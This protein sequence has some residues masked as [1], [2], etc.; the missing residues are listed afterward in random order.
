[1]QVARE[2]GDAADIRDAERDVVMRFHG[3]AC[4]CAC[5]F[6]ARG[7]EFDDLV[8]VAD[9]GL[10]K[11]AHNWRPQPSGGFLQYAKPMIVGELRR[12]FR[13]QAPVIRLPRRLQEVGAAVAM[14]RRALSTLGRN[15]TEQ[16]IADT[17]GLTIADIRADE[18]ARTTAEME[19]LE[20]ATD[21]CT[22]SHTVPD[23]AEAIEIRS[24]VRDAIGTLDSRE[25]EMLG[26]RYFQ[27]YTQ[28]QIGDV[29]G[30]SQ[31]QVSR[32]LHQALSKLQEQLAA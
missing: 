8:Q 23:T 32:L 29:L 31:M 25:R 12:Y 9:V 24:L 13:D 21:L 16:E 3:F 15:P 28:Q 30:I 5:R 18:V 7:V 20:N 4:A 22:E 14:A 2:G 10:I 19:S 17:A 11:A 1:L 6:T 27:D 26:M